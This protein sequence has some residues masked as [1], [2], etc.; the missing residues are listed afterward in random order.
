MSEDL[1][2]TNISNNRL[3]R[4]GLS[5]RFFSESTEQTMPAASYRDKHFCGAQSLAE[6]ST[7][8]AAQQIDIG[9]VVPP[10]RK[11]CDRLLGRKCPPEI[12]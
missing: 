1:S 9:I 6:S 11:L 12:S 7:Q 3:S 8:T 2:G 10:P 5:E 4:N